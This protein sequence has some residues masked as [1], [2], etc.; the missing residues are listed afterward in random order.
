MNMRF[1]PGIGNTGYE[2]QVYA[3]YTEDPDSVDE[4]WQ[5]YFRQLPTDTPDVP[6]SGRPQS[7]PIRS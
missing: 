4:G 1:S 3:A 5:T 7:A 6:R 2:E